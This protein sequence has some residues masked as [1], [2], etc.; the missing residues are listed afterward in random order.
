M[1]LQDLLASLHIG[2]VDG[3]LTVKAS[4]TEQ[5]GIQNIGAVGCRDDDDTVMRAKAVHLDEQ[6]V[7]SLL[8][9]V[10]SAAK[11]RASVASYGI[12]LIDKDDGSGGFARGFKQI[13]YAR[14]TDTDV[15]L[16]E[17]RTGNGVERNTRLACHCLCKQGLTGT[18]RAHEQY[19][20]GDLCAKSC[21]FGRIL[22]E[23]H[24]LDKL[25]LLLVR[26]RDVAEEN[27]ALIIGRG[28]FDTCL[29]KGIEL[30]RTT[31]GVELTEENDIDHDQRDQNQNPGQKAEPPRIFR[32]GLNVVEH[33][34]SR[35]YARLDLLVK[36]CMEI[37]DIRDLIDLLLT[38]T[39]YHD[40][41]NKLVLLRD[42]D[43]YDLPMSEIGVDCRVILFYL[44][45]P[46]RKERGKN[47]NDQSQND[48][49]KQNFA[50]ETAFFHWFLRPRFIF[51]QAYRD[52]LSI[53]F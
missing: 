8:A 13:A 46:A 44:L 10:V 47:K 31:L 49:V 52:K 29:A 30:T 1:Y 48:C 20:V 51:V 22:E 9:F 15:H 24:D 26:T 40:V 18:G 3:D 5:C 34:L 43:L 17:I 37:V 21:E 50:D 27:A 53:A 16:Y 14:C 35:I 39:V 25:L 4:G 33:D 19:A 2:I 36:E 7:Q 38:D 32:R 12:D 6:L 23:L 45:C 41:Q 28:R 11:T 42:E